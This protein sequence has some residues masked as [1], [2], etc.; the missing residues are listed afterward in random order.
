MNRGNM[1][2]V[3]RLVGIGWY[4]AICI[5]GGTLGGL[6]LDRRVDTGPALTLVGLG[7]GIAMAVIG[8]VKMLLAVLAPPDDSTYEDS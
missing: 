4:V 2:T 8:M 1:G 6:W 7:I 3:L 5:A